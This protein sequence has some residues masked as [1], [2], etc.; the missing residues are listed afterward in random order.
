MCTLEYLVLWPFGHYECNAEMRGDG[1]RGFQACKLYHIPSSG[2]CRNLARLSRIKI[3]MHISPSSYQCP[4]LN[5]S[6]W[7]RWLHWDGLL[8]LCLLKLVPGPASIPGKAMSMANSSNSY[9]ACWGTVMYI[10]GGWIVGFGAN[11]IFWLV[12]V[13]CC[14]VLAHLS[15]KRLASAVCESKPL[16][17]VQDTNYRQLTF[18][19]WCQSF[20]VERTTPGSRAFVRCSILISALYSNNAWCFFEIFYASANGIPCGRASV[21]WALV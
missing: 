4:A 11:G 15:T 14:G 5:G 8:V 17:G 6:R 9:I 21:I 13:E 12:T 18:L 2:V 10:R 7:D 19:S 3:V 1:P 16:L 20:F